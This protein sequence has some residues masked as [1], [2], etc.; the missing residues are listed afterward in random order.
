MSKQINYTF[1]IYL[2]FLGLVATTVQFVQFFNGL[3][4]FETIL[5]ISMLVLSL[6]LA[7]NPSKYIDKIVDAISVKIKGNNNTK[8][9][10][11]QS[12]GGDGIDTREEM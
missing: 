1:T 3:W 2:R 8:E 9:Y 5:E 10:N 12:V 7:I 6:A 4:A 11:Q